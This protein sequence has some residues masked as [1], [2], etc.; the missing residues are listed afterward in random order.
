[1]KKNQAFMFLILTAVALCY[2]TQAVDGNISQARS[3]K[4]SY[5]S[6][7]VCNQTDDPIGVMIQHDSQDE[8]GKAVVK[9]VNIRPKGCLGWIL[10]STGQPKKLAVVTDEDMYVFTKIGKTCDVKP[11]GWVQKGCVESLKV[12]EMPKLDPFW[13][14]ELDVTTGGVGDFEVIGVQ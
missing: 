3:D 6:Y 9:N 14:Y 7:K 10:Q 1:M 12:K 13:H 4:T 5:G 8:E 2:E 11:S